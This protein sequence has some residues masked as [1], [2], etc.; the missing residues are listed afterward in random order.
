MIKEKHGSNTNQSMLLSH[1]Q[2]DI[3]F[4]IPKI[5]FGTCSGCPGSF[6]HWQHWILAAST[7]AK[8]PHT[9]HATSADNSDCCFWLCLLRAS[10]F[11]WWKGVGSGSLRILRWSGMMGWPMLQHWGCKWACCCSCWC[12]KRTDFVV[13]NIPKQRADDPTLVS[14]NRCWRI[15]HIIPTYRSDMDFIFSSQLPGWLNIPSGVYSSGSFPSQVSCKW[16][17]LWCCPRLPA[18]LPRFLATNSGWCCRFW[19]S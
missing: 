1:Q 4:K 2:D 11:S 14:L 16:Q 8:M 17:G 7:G 12:L 3:D 10:L 6:Y 9:D 15:I 13:L 19:P 18:L 5:D